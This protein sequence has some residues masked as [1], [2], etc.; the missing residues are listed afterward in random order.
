MSTSDIRWQQRL[1]NYNRA[2]S[3]LTRA[4]EL[5][6]QRSLSELER[7]GLIKAYE[8]TYEL[9]WNLIKDYFNFQGNMLITGS[10][11]AFR[12]AFQRELIIEGELWMEM[13]Q[14]RNKTAHTYNETVAVEIANKI[15]TVYH[16]LFIAL[17]Q[18]MQ[19]LQEKC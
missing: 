13:V 4:V 12:E 8:F 3:Q 10:R 7:Q 6:R 1:S 14:D 2:L 17:Q 16:P 15:V 19:E 11:D 9:S 18:K 5:S